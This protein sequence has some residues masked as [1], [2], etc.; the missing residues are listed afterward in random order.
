ML[1]IKNEKDYFVYVFY[2]C[3]S[4]WCII[5]SVEVIAKDNEMV[6]C[7][8]TAEKI[9]KGY[10]KDMNTFYKDIEEYGDILQKAQV[11]N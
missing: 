4:G 10:K 1:L 9:L 11:R 5:N 8:K 3:N 6:D 2:S 7:Q